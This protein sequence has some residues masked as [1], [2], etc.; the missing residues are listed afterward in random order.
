MQCT[1]IWLNLIKPCDVTKSNELEKEVLIS[2]LLY[3]P[4][5]EPET[6]PMFE[7][8]VWRGRKMGHERVKSSFEDSSMWKLIGMLERDQLWVMKLCRLKSKEDCLRHTV[9]H[10]QNSGPFHYWRSRVLTLACWLLNQL[11][12]N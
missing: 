6:L 7:E 1:I 8:K 2:H 9:F 3:F 4:N 5:P 12:I 11:T 10:L